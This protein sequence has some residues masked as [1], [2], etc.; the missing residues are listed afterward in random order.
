TKKALS[1][2]D[3]FVL[4]NTVTLQDK[5]GDRVDIEMPFE[6]HELEK[7]IRPI[8]ERT[9][10]YCY[11]AL[12]LAQTK[13]DITLA[14]VDAI[15]LA[16]GTTHIPLVREIVC[17]TFCASPDAQGVRAKCSEPVYKK[18]DTDVTLGSAIR[19]A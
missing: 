9:I 12:E 11:H 2:H 4:R 3:E 16:G 19:T 7:L 14:D 1:T 18:V 10:P 15:I 13:A 5:A 8:V 17:N 6:R